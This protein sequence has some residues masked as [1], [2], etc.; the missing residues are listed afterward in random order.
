MRGQS[1]KCMT[2]V[3]CLCYWSA[4]TGTFTHAFGEEDER[5]T[6]ISA[7]FASKPD[8]TEA[9]ALNRNVDAERASGT[10]VISGNP[11]FTEFS[12]GSG[13][14]GR[15]VQLPEEWG[16]RFGGVDLSDVNDVVRG[17]LVYAAHL[18]GG[19]RARDVKAI[20]FLR[21]IGC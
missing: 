11:A 8:D 5:T 7:W 4:L 12:A 20:V 19:L 16:V 10:D 9:A 17:L 3:S 1:N 18:K 15:W 14:L 21:R 13:A 6:S 2:F